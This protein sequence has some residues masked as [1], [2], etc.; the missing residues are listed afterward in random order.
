MRATK[1]GTDIRREQIAEAAVDLIAAE[2]ATSLSI[3]GIAARV[4]I[5]PSAFYRHFKSKDEVLD[6]VLDQLRVALLGNVATVRKEADKAPERLKRLLR[7]HVGLLVEKRAIQQM[8]FSDSIYLGHPERKAKVKAIVAG[9]LAEVQKIVSEGQKEGT[10]LAGLS[11]ETVAVMFLGLVLP[12]A[13]IRNFIGSRL[14]IDRYVAQAWPVFAR[15]IAAGPSDP[16]NRGARG[17]QP[18]PSQPRGDKWEA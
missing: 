11:P 17:R 8:V 13:V 10:L 2:G 6:A 14:D 15:G 12:T 7:R 9:Y 5:A 18:P 3:A 1:T 4:G 16:G